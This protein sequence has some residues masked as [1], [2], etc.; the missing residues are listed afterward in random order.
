LRK[1]SIAQIKGSYS[2]SLYGDKELRNFRTAVGSF[3]G[4]IA[5]VD[6]AGKLIIKTKNGVR[7][8]NFKEVQF[9]FEP[10]K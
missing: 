6:D 9:D 4:E 2:S 3:E 8:F 7:H 5:G 10:L 1:G